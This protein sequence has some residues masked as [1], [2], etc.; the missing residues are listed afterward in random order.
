MAG[1]KSRAPTYFQY[2]ALYEMRWRI[3]YNPDKPQYILSSSEYRHYQKISSKI[4]SYIS[5]EAIVNFKLHNVWQRVYLLNQKHG[6]DVLDQTTYNDKYKLV[7]NNHVLFNHGKKMQVGIIDFHISGNKLILNGHFEEFMV[8]GIRAYLR[9]NGVRHSE[10]VQVANAVDTTEMC[11]EYEAYK[12]T[13]FTSRISLDVSGFQYI[14]FTVEI[15]DKE[16]P[17]R[18]LNIA[19]MFD[20][21]ENLPRHSKVGKHIISWRR[22]GMVIATDNY[23]NLFRLELGRLKQDLVKSVLKMKKK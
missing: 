12:R 5:D 1:R 16:F 6:I 21:D 11:L 7:W 10:M 22:A 14:D 17:V 2:L 3:F 8:K 19:T 20:K 15:K 18:R 13:A 9:V 4:L 23:L